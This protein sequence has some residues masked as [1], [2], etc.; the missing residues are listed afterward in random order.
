MSGL[1]SG[2]HSDVGRRSRPR[3][4][5]ELVHSVASIGPELSHHAAFRHADP[6]AIDYGTSRDGM[7]NGSAGCRTRDAA[8]R[9]PHGSAIDNGVRWTRGHEKPSP[10][11][12][13]RYS[14]PDK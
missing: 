7:R 8:V 12:Q 11:D 5:S 6:L 2:G 3:E 13:G 4:Q 14:Q 10:G 9:H 1:E